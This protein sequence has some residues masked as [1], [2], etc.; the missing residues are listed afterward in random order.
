MIFLKCLKLFV[1]YALGINRTYLRGLQHPINE[2]GD[3]NKY[4]Y[5]FNMLGALLFQNQAD[6]RF[7]DK[8]FSICMM[9]I[10]EKRNKKYYGS[11]VSIDGSLFVH[12]RGNTVT[13]ENNDPN[14]PVLAIRS[15]YTQIS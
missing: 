8:A 10:K 14:K 5:R 13:F 2:E 12:V 11:G 6:G 7:T 9:M 15:I 3:I 4:I 1:L